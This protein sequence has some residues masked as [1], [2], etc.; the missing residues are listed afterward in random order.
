MS[1]ERPAKAVTFS[2][3][4]TILITIVLALSGWTLSRVSDVS[5]IV[6]VSRADAASQQRDIDYLRIRIAAV[7][8]LQQKLQVDIVK[9]SKP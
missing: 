2:G 9:L 8:T 3:V 7:E 1:E 5:T 4:N 6:A